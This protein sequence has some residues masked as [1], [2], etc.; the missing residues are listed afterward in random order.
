MN[1]IERQM[2]E[3]LKEM[4][5]RYG[6]VAVKAEFEAEG[7][8]LEE[9]MRLEEV[10]LRAGLWLFL[11]TGGPEDVWGILQALRVGV[12]GIV[13]PMVEG[14][15][16]LSKF[17]EAVKTYVLDDE[18]QGMLVAVNVETAQSVGNLPSMLEVGRKHGLDA[19]TIGRVDLSGSM[20]FDPTD[21]VGS[22]QRARREINSESVSGIVR[23]VCEKVKRTGML[24]TMGGGIEAASEDF[25]NEL[26]G[27][28]LLDRFET[29]KI[30]FD[31]KTAVENYS[32]AVLDAHRFELMW[33]ENKRQIH[34]RAASEDV[35]RIE[36]LKKRV[37]T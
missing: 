23:D 11:K 14:A 29:R 32:A 31:G 27:D 16:A 9:L 5:G 4:R 3:H 21:P 7:T 25:I 6:V 34:G 24:V 2:V 17:L 22:M 20:H 15:Y 8:R 30:V 33:L 35:S 28:K 19:V 36:M 37:G 1:K 13:A 10:A 18:R 12:D 26:V